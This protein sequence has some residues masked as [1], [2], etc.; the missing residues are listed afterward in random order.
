MGDIYKWDVTRLRGILTGF[1]DDAASKV[2]TLSNAGDDPKLRDLAHGLKGAAATAGAT[3][4][5]RLAADIE[6]AAKTDNSEAVALLLPLL[7]PTFDE[8][9]AALADFLVPVPQGAV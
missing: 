4:L 8:L 2:A 9:K 5:A 7:A 6:D 1:L 3:R